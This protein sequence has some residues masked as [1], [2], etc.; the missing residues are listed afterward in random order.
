MDHGL[1]FVAC[2]DKEGRPAP[3]GCH[4]QC[5]MD[6]NYWQ[7]VYDFVAATGMQLLFGLSPASAD[8]ANAL[9]DHTARR[10]NYTA[11]SMLGYSFGNE[12]T[13]KDGSLVEEYFEKLTSVRSAL[14]KAY[15][16]GGG[17]GGGGG[18]PALVAPDTGIGPRHLW[19]TPA[20]I[21][22][23]T[24]IDDHLD[25]VRR[26]ARR[27]GPLLDAITWHEYDF[28]SQELGG[29]DHQPWPYPT[30][31][32]ASANA[33]RFWDPA[34]LDVAGRLADNVSAAV[35]GRSG[36]GPGEGGDK[37][38]WLT[39]TNSV[40]HQGTFNLTNAFAN[41]LWLVDRLGLMAE[42]G[43]PLMGRQSLIGYVFMF[44]PPQPSA[45]D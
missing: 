28:R 12:Q 18:R 1:D 26:F 29:A 4:Q 6:A 30:P 34:Y 32:G 41:S 35:I 13:D 21:A 11:A 19:I 24:S 10:M 15:P 44:F 33:S 25:Y 38:V 40:C 31:P 43:V 5:T 36:P 39:E 22:N 27:C 37:P 16:S 20:G 9:I 8:N 3:L 42:R 23:D 2:F 45:S 7:T 14:D 17:G